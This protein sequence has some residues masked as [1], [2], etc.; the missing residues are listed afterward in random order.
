M[1]V[2]LNSAPE[3]SEVQTKETNLSWYNSDSSSSG[4]NGNN[5]VEPLPS[6]ASGYRKVYRKA[7]GKSY[8][9]QG[10]PVI[11]S[12]PLV[13]PNPVVVEVGK[14]APYIGKGPLSWTFYGCF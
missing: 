3:L 9:F 14:D 10:S 13:E 8:P 6:L 5:D 2:L 4:S 11:N 7:K 1:H 12:R